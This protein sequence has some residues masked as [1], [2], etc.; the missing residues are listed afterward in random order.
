MALLACIR[1]TMSSHHSEEIDLVSPHVLEPAEVTLQKQKEAKSMERWGRCIIIAVILFIFTL[2]FIAGGVAH[3][4]YERLTTRPPSDAEVVALGGIAASLNGS[5]SACTDFATFVGH[6]LPTGYTLRDTVVTGQAAAFLAGYW[7][8]SR[9]HAAYIELISPS[10]ALREGLSVK[11]VRMSKTSSGQIV[12]GTPSSANI[13]VDVSLACGTCVGAANESIPD[14][15]H[16]LSPDCFLYSR[17]LAR[18]A[19][20][21]RCCDVGVA[22]SSSLPAAQL[23]N[24]AKTCGFFP[25]RAADATESANDRAFE[26]IQETKLMTHSH[27]VKTAVKAWP[28]LYTDYIRE[29]PQYDASPVAYEAAIQC[30][31]SIVNIT[32]RSQ[33]S[34]AGLPSVPAS[35]LSNAATFDDMV[36]AID[37]NY[38][39]AKFDNPR[40]AGSWPVSPTSDAVKFE[41]GVYFIPSTF[42]WAFYN[43][44][45][46]GLGRLV[47]ALAQ[48]VATSFTGLCSSGTRAEAAAYV[49]NEYQHHCKEIMNEAAE[50][51]P[52]KWLDTFATAGVTLNSAH[53]FNL[54]A[55]REIGP[56]NVLRG[57][58]FVKAF[59][60]RGKQ[61]SPCASVP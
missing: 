16:G 30:F 45:A 58:A 23:R 51:T 26:L 50:I 47:G 3:H 29:Q 8:L 21:C 61:E 20:R 48:S 15:P 35:T 5:V 25:L 4:E 14:I 13:T 44:R 19:E 46:Y 33:W 12:V 24:P 42:R 59:G 36:V 9:G 39:A 41:G 55:A 56:S 37:A 22:C 7:G 43:L 6:Q 60:C 18:D 10:T 54:G 40:A 57:S 11:G 38:H 53:L 1:K 49:V 34:S 17:Q 52:Q 32:V 27:A 2:G 28:S 31:R